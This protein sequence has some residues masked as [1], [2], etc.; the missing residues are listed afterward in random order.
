MNLARECCSQLIS[1]STNAKEIKPTQKIQVP[2][3]F[4][5]QAGDH[6]AT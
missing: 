6:S 4:K 5:F 2:L 3:T 1:G